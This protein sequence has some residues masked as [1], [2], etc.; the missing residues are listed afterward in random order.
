MLP[1]EKNI[2]Y[3]NTIFHQQ[4]EKD[5]NDTQRIAYIWLK[6]LSNAACS[7]IRASSMQKMALSILDG[8]CLE[9]LAQPKVTPEHTHTHV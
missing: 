8:C 1:T 4:E 6:N 5:H 9:Y 3:K 7:T 2:V